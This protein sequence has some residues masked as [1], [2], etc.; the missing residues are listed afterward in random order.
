MADY[1]VQEDGFKINLED[2]TG[3]LLLEDDG[4]Q[5]RVSQIPVDV[6]I[7]EDAKARVSQ[8]TADVAVQEDSKARVSQMYI[9]VARQNV[10]EFVQITLIEL[11]P[12]NP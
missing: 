5:A 12:K 1:L 7:A 2:G 4:G 6:A 9:E 11:T 3:A 10:N 8:L